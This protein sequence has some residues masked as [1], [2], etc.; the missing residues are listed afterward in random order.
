MKQNL[1]PNGDLGNALRLHRQSETHGH[2]LGPYIHD[3]VYGGNDGIVT[4][5]AIVAGTVGAELPAYV[6]IILGLANLLGDG[7]SMAAG[8]Y[9]SLKTELD[10]YERLSKEERQE[11]RDHPDLEREEVREAYAAKGL[12][13]EALDQMVQRTTENEAVWIETMMREEHGLLRETSAQPLVHGFVTF[14]SFV[15]FGSVP[16]LP[17]IFGNVSIPRFTVAILSTF[18]ALAFLGFTRSYVTQQRR[19]R[20]IL[21]IMAIGAIST[22]AAYL[23]GVLLKEFVSGVL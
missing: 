10:Q 7:I 9:L 16:L 20:G 22:G 4:T 23:V 15:V 21:E 5:F 8:A 2:G 1:S 17:Y 11:I 3:I 14:C 6:I 12:T 18:S 19:L 13:G